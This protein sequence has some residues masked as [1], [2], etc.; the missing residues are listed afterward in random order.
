VV[1]TLL[2]MAYLKTVKKAKGQ[3]LVKPTLCVYGLHD[4]GFLF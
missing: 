2:S 3:F 4:F 1:K